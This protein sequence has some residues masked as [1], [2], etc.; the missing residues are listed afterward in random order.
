MRYIL[1]VLISTMFT[2]CGTKEEKPSQVFSLTDSTYTG[3]KYYFGFGAV[4]QWDPYMMHNE[5]KYD[6]LH[7]HN[8]FTRKIGGSYKGH[9]E[10][11]TYVNSSHV[12]K[13]W[14]KLQSQMKPDDMYVQYSSS[15]GFQNGLAVGVNYDE[16]RDQ[17]LSM[18]AKEK[19]I[20]TMACHSGG[21]VNAFNQKR[22]DWENLQNQGKNLLVFASSQVWETSATGP[23][24][25]PQEPAGVTGSAGSAFGHALWKALI[26][27]AD[28]YTSGIKDGFLNLDEILKFTIAKTKQIGGHTPVYTGSFDK[29]LIM[30]KVP[31]K[32]AVEKLISTRVP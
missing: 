14:R 26:G 32:E 28:G 10:I 18:P 21:L 22:A 17:V 1:F 16:I 25:D 20:F 5:V 13:Q 23:G 19:I 12:R 15:H 29:N 2:A 30:N 3:S 27:Q 11:G 9:T 6:V 31:T 8:I 7:T 24:T 4:M